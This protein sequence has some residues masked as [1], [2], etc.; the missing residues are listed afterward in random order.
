MK[1]KIYNLII[2]DA[3]GSMYSISICI[4]FYINKLRVKR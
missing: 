1:Q 4:S 2:L 3:S